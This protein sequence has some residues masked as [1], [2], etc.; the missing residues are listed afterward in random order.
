MNLW[1]HFVSGLLLLPTA[2]IAS[3][4]RGEAFRRS[5]DQAAARRLPAGGFEEPFLDLARQL[6]TSYLMMRCP[7][8]MKV[9]SDPFFQD[10]ES[11]G[12]TPGELRDRMDQVSQAAQA[13]KILPQTPRT[14]RPSDAELDAFLAALERLKTPL[15][16][17]RQTPVLKDS[18]LKCAAQCTESKLKCS[19]L[20]GIP[21]ATWLD[22][23]PL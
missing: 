7:P 8:L 14:P 16:L 17:A 22:L 10:F 19:V 23:P 11:Q 20:P 4:F 13:L 12:L 2:A 6:K 9:M 5:G 18:R 3:E 21:G 1:S 15:E